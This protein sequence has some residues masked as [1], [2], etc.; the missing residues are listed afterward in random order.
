[1]IID[2]GAT[3]SY[4]IRG[5]SAM[6][7]NPEAGSPRGGSTLD[8]VRGWLSTWRS[9]SRGSNQPMVMGWVPPPHKN[10]PRCRIASH[11]H[12]YIYTHTHTHTVHLYNTYAEHRCTLS[13]DPNQL[14]GLSLAAPNRTNRSN[15]TPPDAGSLYKHPHT[16]PRARVS[17][18][19]PPS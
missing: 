13:T 1:M 19:T 2:D 18:A 11:T 7:S 6:E 9:G 5:K 14:T 3:S 15:L 16:P 10:T 8:R 12:I 4:L 17:L